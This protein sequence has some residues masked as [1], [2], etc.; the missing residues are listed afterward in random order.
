MAE[1]TSQADSV[2]TAQ[3][4]KLA[5]LGKA[6]ESQANQGAQQQFSNTASAGVQ[7]LNKGAPEEGKDGAKL[8][9][10]AKKKRKKKKNKK[11]KKAG[12]IAFDTGEQMSVTAATFVP[13]GAPPL[14]I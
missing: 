12:T 13:T 11:K 10:P 2:A 7:T 3:L 1:T 14:P 4:E 8:E 6:L 9:E 5:A